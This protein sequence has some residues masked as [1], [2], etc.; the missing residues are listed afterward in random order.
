MTRVLI[1]GANG[2]LGQ[3]LLQR[4]SPGTG[5]RA[6]VRSAAA[7]RAIARF[8]DVEIRQV[9]YAD[10]DA[11]AGA[12]QHVESVVHLV[13]ILKQT[14]GSTYGAAHEA[15]CEALVEGARRGGV[16]PR[17]VYLSILGAA[18][19]HPNA[20]LASKGR[21]ERILMDSGLPLT[22]IQVP[23]VLGE[24]DYASR[25]LAHRARSRLS[26]GFRMSSL[27]QPI[28]AGDVAQAIVMATRDAFGHVQLA[29]PE[30][31]TRHALVARAGRVLHTTPRTV[32]LPLGLG[33]A[34]AG[35]LEK[36][37]GNPPMTRAMLGVLD[38][39]DAIDAGA[40]AARLG[41]TLTPLDETLRLVLE[42]L[43]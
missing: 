11:I 10:P 42:P 7:A 24:D 6:V 26:L 3:R 43:S 8:T 1:T 2:H 4:L 40:A 36:L 19:G 33:M 17:V 29:G 22:V 30:S 5:V 13:G 27:E 35:L 37:L 25:A 31:L 18:P 16:S 32:S 14:A 34:V 15:A 21:A 38:H 12:L 20:C 39:D 28:Y 41:I 23:M 9:D